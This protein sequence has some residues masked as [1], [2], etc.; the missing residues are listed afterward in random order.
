VTP[1]ESINRMT[2]EERVYV[3]L[4]LVMLVLGFALYVL[5]FI[6][7]QLVLRREMSLW[8]LLL[9]SLGTIVVVAE[10]LLG[11]A[12]VSRTML[13][14]LPLD[15]VSI[16]AYTWILAPQDA[17]FG[18]CILFVVL[19]AMT[20]SRSNALMAS[21]GL[22]VAYVVGQAFAVDEPTLNL[23]LVGLKAITLMVVGVIVSNAVG[24]QRER[25]LEIEVAISERE[26]MNEQLTRRV[27]ELQAV[28]E[29]TEVIHSSLDF[30]E[31]GPLVLQIIS[32]V[33]DFP[34]LAVFVLDKEKSETL[35]SASVGVPDDG[36][37][38]ADGPLGLGEIEAHLT[39]VRVF[40][41]GSIMVL[42]CGG[43]EDME[44]LTEDDR[45]V[46][47]ALASELVV[48]VENSRL[49]KLTRHLSVTDELTGMSNYRYLQQRLDEEVSRARRYDKH[50]SLLMLD[51]DN[52]KGF[53]DQH[54]HIAGDK[55]LA[56]LGQVLGSVVRE[57]DVAA[58]YGGEEFAV[59]LPET[60]AAGAYVA[61]DKIRESLAGHLFLDGE[62]N[63]CCTLTVSIGIAT[64][65]TYAGDMEALLREAD[66]AL[67]RA[68][69]G[70][71]NRVCAPLR[72]P[73]PETNSGD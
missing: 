7:V 27:G 73:V 35:F 9:L 16:A 30:D 64:Y 29:I 4:R 23:V 57:V 26:Q 38:L 72:S 11:R 63:R 58:R 17:F 53:N 13:W 50:L 32:K 55:A 21:V 34:A 59:V 8:A 14:V 71:R 39:C 19:F 22:A 46:I 44:R 60:D 61:A 6:P 33:I 49:Y 51:A 40:D 28:A 70:G 25:E 41:H 66:D 42:F 69:N 52:F 65:P 45:L 2:A 36:G 37:V 43:A 18:V 67:Y 31:I 10:L 15:L 5:E 12:R 24:R 20:V 56:E 48:A 62:G 3:V 54:G 47:N 1:Q 68:K